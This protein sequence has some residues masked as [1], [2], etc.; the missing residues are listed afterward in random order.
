MRIHARVS[1]RVLTVRDPYV[2][3]LRNT[4]AVF[5]A[6]HGTLIGLAAGLKELGF[7]FQL[8]EFTGALKAALENDNIIEDCLSI[9][10]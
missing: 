10:L 5:A 2:N 1:K 8:L 7:P 4:V 3:L 9:N 6:G